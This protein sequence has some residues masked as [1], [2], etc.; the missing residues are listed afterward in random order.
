MTACSEDINMLSNGIEE[1]SI[2]D[3]DM[4]NQLMNGDYSAFLSHTVI[5]VEAVL[6]SF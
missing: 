6:A 3:D 2:D 1:V 4:S 5:L